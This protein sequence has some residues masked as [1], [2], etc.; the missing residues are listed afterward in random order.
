VLIQQPIKRLYLYDGNGNVER[1]V[2]A[3]DGSLAAVY[4][5]DPYG[6]LI[7]Q[8]GEY[9]EVNPF[10]FSTKYF[11]GE[12]GLYYY[13]YRYYLSELGRWS[14]RDPIGENGGVNLYGFVG[15]DAINYT[16]PF[17]LVLYAFDGTG[18]DSNPGK[19]ENSRDLTNVWI[20]N[21]IYR[22]VKHYYPGV[23]SAFSTR[24]WGG[25]TGAGAGN[26]IKSAYDHFVKD[27]ETDKEID[28]IGF[29]RGAGL[30]RE[31]AN[32]LSNTEY[33]KFKGYKGCPVNIRFI[34]L[35]DTVGQTM[36]YNLNLKISDRVKSVAHAVSKDERRN[37]FPMTRIRSGKGFYEEIFPG[38]HSDIG[39]GHHT[40][41]NVLSM[42]PLMYIYNKG[43]AAGVPFGTIPSWVYTYSGSRTPHDLSAQL[44]WG[45][46]DN[47]GRSLD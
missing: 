20:L 9:A 6:N 43:N 3:A 21:D 13:G 44:P 14:S 42:A 12:S 8:A 29:S 34:G 24:L 10:R 39:R 18:K 11:D 47:K 7:S 5:Y 31:F 27:Y 23:G 40:G 16:D 15:N 2:D 41:T 32:I 46:W 19:R 30:A 28:I 26:R 17:G 38:D 22:G 1:L 37:A 36:F 45:L 33:E 35:F 4:K 25:A